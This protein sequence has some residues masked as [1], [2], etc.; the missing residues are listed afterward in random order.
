M[1]T[2]KPKPGDKV[3]ILECEE[4]NDTHLPGQVVE[5]VRD[6]HGYEGFFGKPE[7]TVEDHDGSIWYVEIDREGEM[8]ERV[9]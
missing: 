9:E 4:F 7:F 3:R 8:W 1:S 5:V 6:K 2:K